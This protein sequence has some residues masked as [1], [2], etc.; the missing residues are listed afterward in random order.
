MELSSR[1]ANY[2]SKGTMTIRSIEVMLISKLI[3]EAIGLKCEGHQVE[4][5]IKGK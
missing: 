4:R 5:K 3:V 1:F 2:W